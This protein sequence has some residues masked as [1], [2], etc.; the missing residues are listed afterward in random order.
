MADVYAHRRSPRLDNRS[1]ASLHLTHDLP[2]CLGTTTWCLTADAVQRP[3]GGEAEC[4]EVGG[5]TCLRLPAVLGGE[6]EREFGADLGAGLAKEF[7]GE[8]EQIC[9]VVLF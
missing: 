7:L 8:L 3:V 5:Q 6:E 4:V 1:S 2:L 9:Q